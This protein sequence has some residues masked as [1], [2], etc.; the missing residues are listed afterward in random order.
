MSIKSATGWDGDRSVAV[1]CERWGCLHLHVVTAFAGDK[2]P[3]SVLEELCRADAAK[4]GWTR[5]PEG[6][7]LCPTHSPA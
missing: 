1:M 4:A 2:S 7:D 6:T 3:W 5:T